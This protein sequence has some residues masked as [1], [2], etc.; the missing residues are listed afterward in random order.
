[1]TR[2][3]KLVLI[4]LVLMSHLIG[5]I[6][7]GAIFYIAPE[8][9]AEFMNRAGAA[10]SPSFQSG[11]TGP[12][13]FWVSLSVGYMVLVSVLTAFAWKD[14]VAN[15]ICIPITA[16]GKATSSLTCLI[17]LLASTPVF[18]YLANFLVDGSIAV[19]YLVLNRAVKRLG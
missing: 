2:E 18:F 8:G 19:T 9:T 1:M 7:V 10:L 3:K 13:R 15:R 4:K 16:I 14:P 11:V 12:F 5:Y 17:Y 6:V